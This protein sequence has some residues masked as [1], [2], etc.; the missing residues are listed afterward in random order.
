MKKYTQSQ[1]LIFFLLLLATFFVASPP[2]MASP[3]PN[4]SEHQQEITQYIQDIRDLQD[5]IFSLLEKVSTMPIENIGNL[6]AEIHFIYS[7][8]ETVEQKLLDYV[9]DIPKLSPQRRDVLLSLI[10]LNSV[11]NSLYQLIQFIKEPNSVERTLLLEDFYFL[12]TS[13]ANTL[14]KL[15]SIISRE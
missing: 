12:R 8:L 11:E 5:Q 1:L 9:K 10:A 3:T 4:L 13:A 2:L 14:Y 7:N 15:E 6:N